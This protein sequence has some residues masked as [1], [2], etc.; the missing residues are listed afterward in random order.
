MR[1]DP[2]AFRQQVL[3]LLDGHAA[4]FGR[5][6]ADHALLRRQIAQGQDIHSRSTFPGHVTTSAFVL[7]GTG[8]HVLLVAHRA[9][10]RW[11]QPGGHYEPPETLDAS[12][13]R[14][15]AEETGLTGIALDPWHSL[16]RLP[17]D[18]DSHRIPARPERNEPEHWHH[19]IRYVLRA[20]GDA[21][22]RPDTSEV[23]G[24]A[25]RPFAALYDI[26]PRAAAHMQA[27]GIAA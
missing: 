5:P 26:A 12:A 24:A 22:L 11:L 16:T 8:R 1:F 10:G 23:D 25:W 7:D 13:L 3:A 17:I 20:G 19:D 27:L 18:I 21:P 2:A 14:E 4:L 15:A 6:A 9:L